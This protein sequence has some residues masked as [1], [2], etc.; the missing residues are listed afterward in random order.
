MPRTLAGAGDRVEGLAGVHRA[1]DHRDAGPRVDPAVQQRGHVHDDPAEGVHQVDGQ[2]RA[3]GVP[4]GT[5]QGDLDGVRGR[6]ERAGAHAD[7]AGR[8]LRVAVQRVDRGDVLERAGGDH[9]G[10]A[11]RHAL[12]GG[13]EDQPDP[14]G[15]FALAVELREGQAQSEQDRRVYVVTAGVR[16]V[17][18]RG[19]VRHVLGVLQRQGVQV[20]PEGDHP[21]ALADVAEHAVAL[22]QQPRRQAGDG[23]LAG[24][25]GGGLELRAGRLRVRVD[26]PA[27]GYQIGAARG[28]PAVELAGQRVGAGRRTPESRHLGTFGHRQST[29]HV[30]FTVA[31]ENSSGFRNPRQPRPDFVTLCNIILVQIRSRRVTLRDQKRSTGW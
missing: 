11:G 13:L 15:E 27:N 31:F 24:D 10:R 19:P 18:H 8:Q 3:G 22:R 16:D 17:L 25:Q 6:G 2:V 5:G 20:G 7:Q 29:R 1:P 30:G 4:A 12:L 23:Q 28:E 26:V 9:L 21:V 14:A